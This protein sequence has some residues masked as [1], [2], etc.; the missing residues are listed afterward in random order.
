MVRDRRSNDMLGHKDRDQLEFFIT[1]L[2]Y[3]D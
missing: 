3:R 2:T 1:G